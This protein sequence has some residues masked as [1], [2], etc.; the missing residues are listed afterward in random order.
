M[1]LFLRN[2]HKQVY[3]DSFLCFLLSCV[4]V[5][6]RRKKKDRYKNHEVTIQ[7]SRTLSIVATQTELSHS[8]KPSNL[9]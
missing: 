3:N 5:P 7:F 2:F 4:D 8:G 9:K 6:L 1:P